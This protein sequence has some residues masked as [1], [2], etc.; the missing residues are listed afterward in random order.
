MTWYTPSFQ[1]LLNSLDGQQSLC[2]IV[3]LI[4]STIPSIWE[5]NWEI[6]I[7]LIPNIMLNCSVCS[8][9][10]LEPLSVRISPGMPTMEKMDITT[11]ATCS[12]H[13]VLSGI[14]KGYL[15]L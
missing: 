14:A 13:M 15:V 7:A 3:E 8:P 6:L 9:M 10:K 12:N 2:F 11:V 4:C 5:W 1:F